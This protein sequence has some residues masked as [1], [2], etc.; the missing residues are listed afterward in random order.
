M[1][2]SYFKGQIRERI[3][4]QNQKLISKDSCGVRIPIEEKIKQF[5]LSKRK[6]KGARHLLTSVALYLAVELKLR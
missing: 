2:K 5:A 6:R 3:R 1:E 4:S